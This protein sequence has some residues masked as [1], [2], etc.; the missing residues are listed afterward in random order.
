MSL[1]YRLLLVVE[2][3][4]PMPHTIKGFRSVEPPRP[5]P[6]TSHAREAQAA[7]VPTQGEREESSTPL[8]GATALQVLAMWLIGRW[9]P[10]LVF[11]LSL[12]ATL[13][14]AAF[15]AHV[16]REPD[17]HTPVVLLGGL[18][19]SAIL[20][21]IVR[22]AR[23]ARA[24]DVT[25]LNRAQE[26]L[27]QHAE[28]LR[29]LH[30]IDRAL[31]AG[32]TPEAIAGAVIQPLRKLLG[33]P[34][35]IVNMFDL[36]TNEVEWL[37]AAGRRRV[38]IGP[39]VRY[40]L[41]LAGDLDAL[42]RG[43]PQVIDTQALPPGPAV[44][45]LR[46]SGVQ[47][48]M[49]MPMI[50]GGEL[51]G[52]LS[53]GGA[54]G[55]FPAEQVSI[56]QEAAMQLAIVIAQ[57]RLHERVKHQAERMRLFS[58]AVESSTDAI[59]TETLEGIITG[60]NP[61][62]ELLYGFSAVEAVGQS[63]ALLVPVDRR[64]ELQTIREQLQHGK[65]TK[66]FET[67]R[68]QKD[69]RRIDVSLTMS[70]VMEPEGVV[71]GVSTIARDI[72]ERKRTEEESRAKNQQ[73]SRLNEELLQF[74]YSASHDLKAPLATIQGLLSFAMQDLDKG[75]FHEVRTNLQRAQNLSTEL[76]Q[77]VE[78]VL[79]LAKAD[80]IDA[81]WQRVNIAETLSQIKERLTRQIAEHDVALQIAVADVETFY[82]E[83]TRFTQ[84]MENLISN[85]IKYAAPHKAQRFV[86][87]EM[88]AVNNYLQITISDNGIG[89]PQNRHQDVFKMFKRFAKNTHGSGLGLALV[90]KHV[91]FFQGHIEF[92]SSEN[93]TRF[94]ILI[95]DREGTFAC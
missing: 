38:H 94:K 63:S 79:G 29:I 32:E 15:V 9:A 19:V 95:P 40:S 10:S 48:Y 69:G 84:I 73:L 6:E 7:G 25:K 91:D 27:A 35:A 74:A 92:E 90:K 2:D 37:A 67:V 76:A 36:A 44:D 49:V 58:T 34:R 93:G 62:A 14:M 80:Q 56:A 4:V 78:D 8:R 26:V 72:T 41:Q 28:R 39:G 33:V 68:V 54:P 51:I 77:R 5:P 23:Q 1:Q 16:A 61:A 46:A 59:L 21:G 71:L 11:A 31:I 86:Q 57:A 87:V 42:R 13:G 47:V 66:P 55:P 52:S 20:F 18:A 81:H 88:Y 53:F 50:A 30:E 60:W 3:C 65:R 24:I 17:W 75:D 70:P 43:E 83:P 12:L 82:T 22:A 89:I 45:A 64:D 85:G